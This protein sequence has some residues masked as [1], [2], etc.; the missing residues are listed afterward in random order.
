MK[1]MREE[2]RRENEN[3]ES[4]STAPSLVELLFS[5]KKK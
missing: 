3:E 1:K 4:Y 5:A 2:M